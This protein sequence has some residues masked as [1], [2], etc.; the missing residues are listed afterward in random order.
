ML[1]YLVYW[2][3][4]VKV[5]KG[6]ACMKYWSETCQSRNT[7]LCKLLIQM[8]FERCEHSILVSTDRQPGR[9]SNVQCIWLGKWPS[10]RQSVRVSRADTACCMS[11]SLA[12]HL[13]TI[14]PPPLSALTLRMNHLI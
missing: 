6:S 8:A 13:P 7:V 2:F 3:T 5:N 9:N 14:C 1:S 12:E 4:L 10:H 11:E